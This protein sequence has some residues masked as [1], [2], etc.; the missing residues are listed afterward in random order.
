MFWLLPL[1]GAAI[2]ALTSKDKLKGAL[3]GAAAGATGGAGAG[4]LGAGAAGAA[5]AGGLLGAAGGTGLGAGLTAATGA[6]TALTGATGGALGLQAGLGA[7]TGLTGA[8]TAA[9]GLTA[10]TG[11]GTALTGAAAPGMLS[12]LSQYGKPIMQGMEAVQKSGI[13]GGGEEPP[14]Q[15]QMRQPQPLDLSGILQGNQQ[16]MQMTDEESRRRQK[17]LEQFAMNMMGGRNG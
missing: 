11:T 7:G 17:E 10:A 4:L 15:A 12:Q 8:L 3:M 2:G 6:G 13:M 14:P 5:G 16:A 1:A 9:P